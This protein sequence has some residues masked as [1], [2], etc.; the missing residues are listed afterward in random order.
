MKRNFIFLFIFGVFLSACSTH[1]GKY[2]ELF[3]SQ[4]DWIPVNADFNQATKESN[5]SK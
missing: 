1:Q 5:E 4:K 3:N 2:D